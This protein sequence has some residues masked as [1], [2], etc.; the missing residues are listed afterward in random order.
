MNEVQEVE[1]GMK[2]MENRIED[3]RKKV[4]VLMYEVF[5]G[6]AIFG[7]IHCVEMHNMQEYRIKGCMRFMQ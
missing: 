7:Y 4:Q 1:D 2:C 6:G 3:G 5:E